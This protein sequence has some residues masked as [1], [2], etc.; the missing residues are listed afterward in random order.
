MR[1]WTRWMRLGQAVATKSMPRDSY[2][3]ETFTRDLSYVRQLARDMRQRS[4]AGARSSPI[5]SS[6]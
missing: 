2:I 3:R 1:H 5:I 6:L 4:R